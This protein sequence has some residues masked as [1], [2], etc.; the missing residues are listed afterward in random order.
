MPQDQ[1]TLLEKAVGQLQN[2]LKAEEGE[3][4]S[5]IEV[6][7]RHPDRYMATTV[8]NKLVTL[9][10][11]GYHSEGEGRNISGG[12]ASE[13]AGNRTRIQPARIPVS[14]I[15]PKVMVNLMLAIFAGFLGAFL[16]AFVREY[17]DD[18]LEKS[19]DIEDTLE[20][21]ILAYI[22][23]KDRITDEIMGT[24]DKKKDRALKA[25]LGF[26]S[27]R[28]SPNPKLILVACLIIIAGIVILYRGLDTNKEGPNESPAQIVKNVFSAKIDRNG[29]KSEERRGAAQEDPELPKK[30]LKASE[31]MSKIPFPLKAEETS[32]LEDN[33]AE[34]QEDGSQA[35]SLHGD[36]DEKI[37]ETSLK[38][39]SIE[40]K[41]ADSKA[42]VKAKEADQTPALAGKAEKKLESDTPEKK[43]EDGSL[44]NA[45]RPKKK[46]AD[47][48]P[49]L[50]K[51]AEK[52]YDKTLTQKPNEFFIQVGA[53]GKIGRAEMT[54][55]N[56]RENGFDP[57]LLESDT[58]KNTNPP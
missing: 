35:A 53:F 12:I 40:T 31:S 42:D 7:F 28:F 22:P 11:D 51:G 6:K 34:N 56:L 2:D 27:F 5:V 26:P 1:Q 46:E 36:A 47:E 29:E 50:S 19:D 18:S 17:L 13:K 30:T 39:D 58:K 49:G 57:Y 33:K 3:K 4:S 15:K 14:P 44:G 32:L 9:Y 45:Q 23:E 8:V 54:T 20:L 41:L 37:I 43:S 25:K 16:L 48:E 38:E 21:P 55:K 24:I 52:K 10:F